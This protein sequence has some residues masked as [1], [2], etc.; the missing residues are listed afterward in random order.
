MSD[1]SDPLITHH[2]RIAMLCRV[3]EEVYWLSRNIERAVAV[4]RLIEVTWHLELDS[5]ESGG[6]HEQFWSPLL[7][8]LDLDG[9][10]PLGSVPL[11]RDELRHWLAFDRDNPNSLVS[12]L[13]K[14]RAA[15]RGVREAISSEMWEQLNTLVLDL[16]D[17]RRRDETAV[18]PYGFYKQAR[19]GARYFQGLAD[20]TLAHDEV[21]HFFNL[22][23]YLERADCVARLLRVQAPLLLGAEGSNP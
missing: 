4:G 8:P 19:E 20:A 1:E 17:V 13:D 14:A 23:K 22:G 21:W 15:A 5:G 2:W 7:G 6:T 16:V 11:S 18:N 3:A 9:L 12:C 10:G